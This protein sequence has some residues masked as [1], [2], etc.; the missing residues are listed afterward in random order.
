MNPT[1]TY[2]EPVAI[3]RAEADVRLQ[4]NPFRLTVGQLYLAEGDTS[5][6]LTGTLRAEREGWRMALDG[7]VDRSRLNAWW[8]YGPLRRRSSLGGGQ[9]ERRQSTLPP[10]VYMDFQYEDT[11]IRFLKTM[12]PITGPRGKRTWW[13][14]DW[15]PRLARTRSSLMKAEQSMWPGRRSSS[16]MLG[17]NRA[18][19]AWRGWW[20]RGR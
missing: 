11:S 14:G 8:R 15:S 16:P 18:R 7:T 12:P 17:S 1:G 4:L 9:S 2:P 6:G 10:D 20:P 13:M 19:L 5:L 3:D